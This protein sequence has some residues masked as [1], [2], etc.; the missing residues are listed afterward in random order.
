[1]LGILRFRDLL[2]LP[3]GSG[4]SKSPLISEKIFFLHSAVVLFVCQQLIETET[5]TSLLPTFYIDFL[6]NPLYKL[7]KRRFKVSLTNKEVANLF[8]FQR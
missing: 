6:E 7:D 1:M 2:L 4:L 3:L 8:L 5:N